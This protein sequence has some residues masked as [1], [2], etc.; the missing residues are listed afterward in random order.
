MMQQA[1][2][3]LGVHIRLLAEAPDVSA[4]QVIPD[5]F[6]GD[7]TDL[8]DLRAAVA[9]APVVTFD[10]E[11]VP[12]EHLRTPRAE[13]HACRP[14]PHALLFAQDKVTMRER[15]A[16]WACRRPRCAS[17]DVGRRCRVVR[18]PGVRQ[19]PAWWL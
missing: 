13:G 12:P 6:V 11:H 10:H 17:V 4:A 5:H 19:D 7:Y 9:D 3:G 16:S 15:S 18:L 1:A 14:G 8:D 2:V